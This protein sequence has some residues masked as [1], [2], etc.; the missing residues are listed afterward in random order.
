MKEEDKKLAKDKKDTCMIFFD[1]QKVLST[2]KTEASYLYYK[3]KLSVYNFTI[4]DV[5]RHGA[6][7][8]VWSDNDAKKGSNED[9]SCLLH[10]MKKN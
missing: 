5:V 3:R 10:Y 2:P 6:V 8:Y 9:S 1:F 7:C 4:Y